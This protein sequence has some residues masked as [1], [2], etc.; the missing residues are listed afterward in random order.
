MSTEGLVPDQAPFCDV[1]SAAM[2]PISPPWMLIDGGVKL[3][4]IT[5]GVIK[6]WQLYSSTVSDNN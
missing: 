1:C 3:P 2:E 6:L 4:E 5:G